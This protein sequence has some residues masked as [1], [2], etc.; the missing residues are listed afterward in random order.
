MQVLS[1]ATKVIPALCQSVAVSKSVV[2][3]DVPLAFRLTGTRNQSIADKY[4]V[5]LNTGMNHTVTIDL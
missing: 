2:I 3:H 5:E 1:L 4:I